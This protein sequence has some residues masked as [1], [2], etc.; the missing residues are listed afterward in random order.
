MTVQSTSVRAEEPDASAATEVH[1]LGLK[2]EMIRDRFQRF[3]DRVFRLRE[4]LEESEPENAARLGRVLQRAGE[5]GL[6]ESLEKLIEL[7]KSASTLEPAHDA[8]TQ[9]LVDA[10]RLLAILLERDSE[11]EERKA[12]LE[13]LQA[14]REQLQ[15]VLGVPVIDPVRAAVE[16]AIDDVIAKNSRS[17]RNRYVV[18]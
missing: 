11:N 16:A 17:A 5:L 12:E 8:Q 7:F 14:Y 9:W 10:D 3:E 4:Q 18:E 13:R 1:P 6:S 2:E 15:T